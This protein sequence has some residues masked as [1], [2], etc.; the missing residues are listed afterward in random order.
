[1]P[2]PMHL[3]EVVYPPFAGFPPE[4]LRFLRRLKRNNTRSWFQAHKGEYEEQVR[5]PM[6]CLI[7]VLGNRMRSAAPEMEFHP[8]KSIFRIYRD[9]RFS[10]D[11]APYKTNI[12]A[13]FEM[14]G[15]KHPTESP[16]LY[17][18]IEPGEIFVGGGVYMPTGDQLKGIRTAIAEHPDGFLEV[19]G[20][21]GFRRMFGGIMGEQLARAPLGYPPDHPHIAHL[22][23][24]QFYVGKIFED[25]VC[26]S[27]RFVENVTAV[28]TKTMPLVRWLARA[29]A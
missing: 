23:Y 10:K 21:K 4:A 11:K 17:L 29:G 15:R 6:Q 1:M 5:F 20:D 18:G 16:G 9:V 8:G 2:K 22:K 14:R 24:K 26:E 27:P 3:D 13:S 28:F 12:A 25:R 19:I 7:A